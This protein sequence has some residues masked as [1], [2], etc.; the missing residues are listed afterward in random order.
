MM[1]RTRAPAKINLTL[2]VVRRRSDGY[3]DLESLVAFAG[4]ADVLELV[5]GPALAL[6]VGGPTA[7]AAG[8]PDGNLVL[9]AARSL[10]ERVS[11]LKAG[12]FR[13]TK[14]LPVGAGIGGGSSDAAAAL[15]LLAQ[16]NDL[17]RGDHRLHDAARATGAD[18]PVCLS[19]R[20]RM[21]RGTGDE[22]DL[23]LAPRQLC[24]VLVNPGIHLDTR[25]VFAAMGLRNG[26]E[27]SLGD[28]PDIGDALE[29]EVFIEA[30]ARARNDMEPAA[31]RLAPE[32]S[33]VLDALRGAGGARLVR[34]SGSGSTCF[35][36]FTD[37]AAARAAAA[38]IAAKHPHWWVRA[39]ALM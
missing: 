4:V 15:R 36:L 6:E 8:N 20:S 21:M 34:M 18:V 16:R 5:P 26:Q 25:S 31:C 7:V 11:G 33:E 9:K 28:H 19:P 23:H 38:A 35:A 14:R 12:T 10:M 30:L 29:R 24:A 37:R 13:L 32:V 27:S 22:L 2:H 39:T 3:H 1:L 17:D